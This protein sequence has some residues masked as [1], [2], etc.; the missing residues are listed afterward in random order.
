[1]YARL[2]WKD[3]RQFW[4]IWVFLASGSGR[5]P[6]LLLHF[7]GQS[8]RYVR[9]PPG[10]HLCQSLV[11]LNRAAAFAGEALDRDT[12][13]T[14]HL[15]D[16]STCRR[17]DKVS[18]ALVT[19]LVLMLVLL[20]MAATSTDNWKDEG[21]LSIWEAITV[22]MI[23]PVAL[24]WGLFWSAILSNAL[25]AAVVAICCTVSL[26]F[27]LTGLDRFYLNQFDLY[28]FVLWEAVLF[29]LT[30][31]TSLIIFNQGVHWKRLGVTLRSPIVVSFPDSTSPSPRCR[32]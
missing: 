32:S 3:A 5:D 13:L 29:V 15:T 2:W 12:P 19:S 1:M 28:A 11:H 6:A 24:G 17:S 9:W 20:A 21:E 18:F 23:V 30:S 10:H 7:L 26:G 25:T 4:S 27:L 8:V 22:G 31:I 16:R 14:R